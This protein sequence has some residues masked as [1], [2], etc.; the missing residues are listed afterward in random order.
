MLKTLEG[1]RT[2]SCRMSARRR[3]C[4]VLLVEDSPTDSH[5]IRVLLSVSRLSKDYQISVCAD[6]NG[7]YE[8]LQR[9]CFD[10]ALL[11]LGQPDGDDLRSLSELHARATCPILVLSDL[12]DEEIALAAM[13]NGAQEFLSKN[14]LDSAGLERTINHSMERHRLME[15]LAKAKRKAEAASQAKSDFLAVMSHEF[16][17]PMNG[18]LSGINL[19]GGICEGEQAR[20]LLEMMREC[21]DSQLTLIGDVLDISKIDAGGTELSCEAFSPRDLIASVLS[22][23]SPT[24]REKGL[25]LAVDVAP[26]L[27]SELVSDAGRLRQVLMNLIGNA[28]K[29]TNEGEVR[30]H[31]GRVDDELIEF[32]V[33]DTG[34]GIAEE[35]LESIFETFT[36]VDSSYNRRY[37]GTGLGLAISE[38]LVGLLGGS[39]R[40]SSSLGEGSEFRFTI[41]CR[42]RSGLVEKQERDSTSARG[43]AKPHPLSVLVVEDNEL[44]RSFLVASLAKIG[45]KA[46]QAASGAE[47]LRLVEDQRFDVI[48]MDIR[49]PGLDGFET[50]RRLIDGRSRVIDEPPYIAAI[51]A[52]VSEDVERRCGAIGISA[53][54]GK[55]IQPDDLQATLDAAYASKRKLYTSMAG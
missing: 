7:A 37:Q 20:G 11:D 21:A 46:C 31:A 22:A 13:Q 51:T 54:L 35:N 50:A 49:M 36:Q 52:S 1:N 23:V 45:Y 10:V 29:F 28:V 4:R 39:I 44:V 40:V 48:F 24:V 9:D 16:R 33:V 30:V 17:T 34:M 14:G 19:L 32:R 12:D 38:R 2:D 8:A 3:D 27:P 5:Y 47:A 43:Q 41:A 6:L 53:L 15:E 26:D 18:I 42:D 25:R 55:P